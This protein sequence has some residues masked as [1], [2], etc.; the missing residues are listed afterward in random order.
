MAYRS[1]NYN[2]LDEVT[3]GTQ[4][5]QRPQADLKGLK[6]RSHRRVIELPKIGIHTL[7][8]P[9][10]K[11]STLIK[12]DKIGDISPTGSPTKNSDIHLYCIYV[13]VS[14]SPTLRQ[15]PFSKKLYCL[16]RYFKEE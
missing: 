10:I 8:Q 7:K 1:L 16:L 5:P 3:I 4:G 14:I 12:Q 15:N 11:L 9:F 6:P 13:I 2:G